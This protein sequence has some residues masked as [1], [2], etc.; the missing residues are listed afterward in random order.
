MNKHSNPLKA[1]ASATLSTC[2]TFTIK[3]FPRVFWQNNRETGSTDS[4]R[5]VTDYNREA[6]GVAFHV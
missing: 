3:R 2:D 4:L 5:D 6:E 1:T